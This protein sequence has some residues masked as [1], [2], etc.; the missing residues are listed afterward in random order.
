MNWALAAAAPATVGLIFW[1]TGLIHPAIV[2]YHILCAVAVWRRR[3]RVR[4]LLRADRST[5]PLDSG[6]DP[7]HRPVPGRGAVR[8][9]S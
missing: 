6:H 3:A 5:L 8:P 4:T 1:A 7:D 2:A 9:R